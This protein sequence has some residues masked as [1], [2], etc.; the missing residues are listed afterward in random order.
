MPT[1][2]LQPGKGESDEISNKSVASRLFYVT[3]I[4]SCAVCAMVFQMDRL[5]SIVQML[6][7]IVVEYQANARGTIRSSGGSKVYYNVR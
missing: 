6:G 5:A 1:A 2:A 4:L 7:H 3:V